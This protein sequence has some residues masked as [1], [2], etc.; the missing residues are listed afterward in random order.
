[1][2]KKKVFDEAVKLYSELSAEFKGKSGQPNLEQ[3]GNILSKLKILIT[4]LN[5]LPTEEASNSQKEMTLA[6]DVIELGALYSVATR[7]IPAF[8]KYVNQLKAYYFDYKD[9][10]KSFF[11]SQLLGL[12]LLCLLAQNQVSDFH[13]EIERLTYDEMQND[14]YIKHPIKIEQYLM[15]GNYNKLFLAKSNIPSES[16]SYF[17]EIL[18]LT[19]RTE[20]AS[21][22]E[23]AYRDMSTTEAQ[24]LLHLSSQKELQDFSKNRNWNFDSK[25]VSFPREETKDSIPAKE[26]TKMMLDYACELEMII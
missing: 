22:L 2:S 19:V 11:R 24:R 15:E 18:L 26:V 1:M 10:P 21:C 16:Y 5:F 9:L 4:Q 8:R 13:S 3:C 20:I 6:R 25:T 14:L 7:D 17:I 23:K 12:N